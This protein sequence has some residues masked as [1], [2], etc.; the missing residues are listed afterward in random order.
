MDRLRAEAG[1]PPK[2]FS[3]GLKL[4]AAVDLHFF[5]HGPANT[6]RKFTS[7]PSVTTGPQGLPG[8]GP[9][10]GVGAGMCLQPMSAQP[11]SASL[12]RMGCSCIGAALLNPSPLLPPSSLVP[13]HSPYPLPSPHPSLIPVPGHPWIWGIRLPAECPSP[14]TLW[15]GAAADPPVGSCLSRETDFLQLCSCPLISPSRAARLAPQPGRAGAIDP[16]LPGLST[17][18]H[19]GH[20]G[21]PGPMQT[22][23][24]LRTAPPQRGP[25]G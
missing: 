17:K 7:L 13:Q 10:S 2:A 16:I 18:A 19:A 24:Q 11:C 6:S 1:R 9:H 3:L 20:T 22:G 15:A 21:Q 23:R 5:S 8:G 14:G 12:C 4:P 25:K